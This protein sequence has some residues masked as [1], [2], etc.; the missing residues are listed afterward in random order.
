[1]AEKDISEK[2]LMRNVD[3]F[4]DCWNILMHGGG[5]EAAGREPT[6]GSTESFYRG[7][8]KRRNE[9]CNVSLYLVKRGGGIIKMVKGV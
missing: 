2:I 3:V 1:M 5:A 9:F 7:K 8:E 6:V 4:A